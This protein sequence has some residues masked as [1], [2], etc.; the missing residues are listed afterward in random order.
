MMDMTLLTRAGKVAGA[1]V[2][3]RLDYLFIIRC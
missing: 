3:R 1:T 2:D